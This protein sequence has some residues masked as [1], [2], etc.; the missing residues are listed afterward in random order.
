MQLS[1][2]HSVI[3]KPNDGTRSC[4][5]FAGPVL[6]LLLTVM[7]MEV[8]LK[9]ELFKKRSDTKADHLCSGVFHI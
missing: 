8:R 4:Q 5:G 9:A 2:S 3:Q 6:S 7:S 1:S